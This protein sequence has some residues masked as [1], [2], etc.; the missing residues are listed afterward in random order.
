[1]KRAPFLGSAVAAV[2]AGCGGGGGGGAIHSLTSV[3]PAVSGGSSGGAKASTAPMQLVP[4]TAPPV[5]ALAMQS[6]IVGQGARFDGA[7]A[8]AG[9]V[10]AQGQ[11][12]SRT[13]YSMVF[14][15]LG[16]GTGGD[17]KTNFVMPKPPFGYMIAIAGLFPGSPTVLASSARA[18]SVAKSMG[19]A[20][21]QPARVKV[22]QPSAQ[23]LAEQRL[24]GSSLR[25][26]PSSAPTV[27]WQQHAAVSDATNDA[28][29]A[30]LGALGGA[31]RAQLDAAIAAAVAGA[32]D[33][34]GAVR[35]VLP[36][37]NGA[38]IDALN[39]ANTAYVQRFNTKW[40]PQSGDNARLAA[41]SFLLAVALS[42]AQVEVIGS[43]E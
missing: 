27:S 38:E 9:W 2:L 21:A 22:K 24:A 17:G 20:N 6:P 23:A 26:G 31:S 43:R 32:T 28:R 15:V 40:S 30:A 5:S 19:S 35:T 12:L 13:T 4:P 39:R 3:L 11:T 42:P 16:P 8:P 7:A 1:V 14:S 25:M 33:L 10:L 41:T 18:P 29:A 34:A 36:V 37:L